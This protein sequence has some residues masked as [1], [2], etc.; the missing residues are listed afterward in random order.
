MSVYGNTLRI[1]IFGESHGPEI[2]VYISGFP[3]EFKINEEELR[4]FMLRRAPGR[5][6]LST[7]RKEADV[8]EFRS[9]LNNSVTNGDTI[10]AVIKNTNQHSNDYNNLADIPRPSHSD[11]PAYVKFDGKCDMRGGGK[12]SGRLTAP[13][14][15]AGGLCM[16]YLRTKNIHIGAHISSI[17]GISDKMFD[18]VSVSVDDFVTTKSFPV[19]DDAKGE[20]M[21]NTILNAKANGDS[22]GGTVEC[23]ILGMPIGYGD[24]LFDGIESSLSSVIFGIPA[25]KGIEFGSGFEGSRLLGSE[26]NDEYF[27]NNGEV[28]TKTN[29]HGGVLGG[30]STSMPIIFNTAFKPTPSIMKE[31]NSIS[32]RNK[33]NVKLKIQGRHD[34]CIV[35]RAVPCVEAAAAVCM[36]DL[37]LRGV[38]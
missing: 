9:G 17:H 29:N 12:F 28:K 32:I 3:K 6:N 35:Q 31:Q 27:Y 16:Q 4:Q 30:I 24:A 14:C 21:I 25:V 5:N 2:G 23:A 11:Y 34:P 7:P 20:E 8:V 26:N 22:V 19:I 33:E 37:L 15:I 36:T 1:E 10:C 13:L 38:K 18:K